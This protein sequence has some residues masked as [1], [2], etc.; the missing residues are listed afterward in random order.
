MVPEE[1]AASVIREAFEGLASGH[2]QTTTEVKRFFEVSGA[3]RKNRHGEVNWET[4]HAILRR[5]LYAGYMGLKNDRGRLR[6]A[7]HEALVSYATWR[8]V[9]DRLDGTSI[10]SARKDFNADF[11]L[12][13]FVC[14]ASCGHPMS[15]SWSKGRSAR[16]PYYT[17][18]Q[19]GCALKGKSVRKE[20]VEGDF[21]S[22]L[23]TLSPA[24][25]M[26]D[27]FG[28][29][30]A[31]RWDQESRTGKE[32]ATA[33]RTEMANLDTK[34]H[35]LV[36]RIVEADDARVIKVYEN[37]I[38]ALD[39]KKA[40]LTEIAASKGQPLRSFEES[41]RTAWAFLSNPWKL[42]VSGSLEHRRLVL[43][44]AFSNLLPYCR[45]EGFRT[46][47][48]AEPLRLLGTFTASDSR[49]VEG[50]GFEPT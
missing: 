13:G 23:E 42:W 26:L 32:R 43:R 18:Y 38:A 49:M 3:I 44:L 35:K 1:P 28:A 24:P 48:I 41:F 25:V 4:A 30:F 29:M 46:A 15:A 40:K 12:R 10:A 50:V 34:V 21:E 47:A 33:A 45:N 7:K 6:P 9:Q 17:C 11:P 16:Y 19:R 36:S 39:D 37:Q 8:K 5:P 14:C 27:V 20:R 2:F 22:L 31:D